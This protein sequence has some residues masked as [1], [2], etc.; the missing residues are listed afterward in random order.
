[1]GFKPEECAVIEDSLPGIQAAIAG[2]FDVFGFATE[3]NK[4]TF[5]ESGATVFFNVNELEHLL[6]FNCT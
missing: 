1:M 4:T 3:K 5:E 6:K 2:G